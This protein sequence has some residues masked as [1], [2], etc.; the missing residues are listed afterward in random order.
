LIHAG[1][2][3]ACQIEWISALSAKLT[4]TKINA[5]TIGGS[6][7]GKT[8]LKYSIVQTLPNELYEV[9]TSA[10]PLS[11]F[12]YVKENGEDSLDGVL[13]YIDEVEASK[14]ALPMLRSLTSQTEITPRH[15]S[16]HE[17]EILDLKI[18][19][20]RS[21]WFTSVKTFGSEQ[22]KNRFIHINP[23][24]TIEQ[25]DRVF[26]LQDQRHRE[27]ADVSKEP[28]NIC[29]AI[30]RIIIQETA[31]M[32]VSIPFKFSWPFK[33]RRFLY[34][35]FLAFIKVI[36]K[37]HFKQRE[38][39]KENRLVA[40][41]EDFMLA[42]KL[43]RTFERSIMYRVSNS[44]LNVLDTL[45]DSPENAKTHSE[46]SETL[47][48]S[49]RWVR[50]LCDELLNEGL[51]NSRKRSKEGAGRLAWE[52][53]KAELPTVEN[54]NILDD[55]AWWR[56]YLEDEAVEFQHRITEL[57]KSRLKNNWGWGNIYFF[58][59]TS[60]IPKLK[61]RHSEVELLPKSFGEKLTNIKQ[62]ILHNKDSEGLV[63][64][65]RLNEKIEEYKLNPDEIVEK[66]KDEGSVVSGPEWGKL[67]VL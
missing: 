22:I 62:W 55:V 50:N 1:D 16:V 5:W 9:F 59:V 27:E 37:V 56:S 32:K 30:A 53:W 64:V 63:L 58:T 52:Y 47:P 60:E 39:D 3:E 61:K 20:S 65:S 8:H 6:G 7:K 4:K 36:V 57:W 38:T 18:K 48:V 49:T 24:E 31:E 11:L 44:A 67:R 45:S 34:P 41:I 51:V 46:I 13:L 26:S 21:V 10:S 2:E 42:K 54:I 19:G 29:K 43:W 28:F 14:F 23:D 35:V 17:A 12:Y 25:D 15:L 40:T 33:K 66:L